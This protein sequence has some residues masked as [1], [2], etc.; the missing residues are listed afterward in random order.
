MFHLCQLYKIRLKVLLTQRRRHICL[1]DLVDLPKVLDYRRKEPVQSPHWAHR[2]LGSSGWCQGE[3]FQGGNGNTIF[4]GMRSTGG[5]PCVVTHTVCQREVKGQ[6]ERANWRM[7]VE[8]WQ[9]CRRQKRVGVFGRS[10]VQIGQK[11]RLTP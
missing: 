2:Q 4:G 11:P 9:L 3:S 10:M 5:V 1:S 6:T 8:R 7:G